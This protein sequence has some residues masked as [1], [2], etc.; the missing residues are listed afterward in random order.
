MLVSNLSKRP[1]WSA[2]R[3]FVPCAGSGCLQ[4]SAAQCQEIITLDDVAAPALHPASDR[5]RR[6]LDC[7][8]ERPQ[9]RTQHRRANRVGRS[10]ARPDRVS[11]RRHDPVRHDVSAV[12]AGGSRI[13]VR[14]VAA[15][16]PTMNTG[17]VWPRAHELERR[18]RLRRILPDRM[19]QRPARR[20]PQHADRARVDP[21]R[22][23]LAHALHLI[24]ANAP[25]RTPSDD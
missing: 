12:V 19:R 21:R 22:R 20:P 18:A 1:I 14:E 5:R 8:L 16:I 24:A 7:L 2:I 23:C 17:F 13:E 9:A 25:L 6:N 3:W 10:G 4:A 11:K 15:N